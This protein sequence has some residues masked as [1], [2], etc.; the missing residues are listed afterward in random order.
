MRTSILALASSLALGACTTFTTDNPA[1]CQAH[2]GGIPTVLSFRGCSVQLT[3]NWAVSA[4]HEPL[5]QLLPNGVADPDLD[6]YFFRRQ[7]KAPTWRDPIPGEPVTAIGNPVHPLDLVGLGMIM[8]NRDTTKGWVKG[9]FP[10][11]AD[12]TGHPVPATLY[13]GRPMAGYSGGPLVGADGAVVGLDY[14]EVDSLPRTNTTGL[15]FDL[16][17]G[18]AIPASAV[19][20]AFHRDT[21]E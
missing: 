13:S 4:K 2:Q 21:G 9:T 11:D 10:L 18:L 7:G 1:D 14:A 17:D 5:R 20:D 3:D 6:L 16:G 19:L 12:E 15:T 8:S